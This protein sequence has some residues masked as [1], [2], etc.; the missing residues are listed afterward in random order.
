MGWMMI[1]LFFS[2]VNARNQAEGVSTSLSPL[3]VMQE[4]TTT[5]VHFL[6]LT[7]LI[8]NPISYKSPTHATYAIASSPLL[9]ILHVAGSL[10]FPL[11]HFSPLPLH[12]FLCMPSLCCVNILSVIL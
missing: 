8:L 11:N 1:R 5:L 4:S 9:S 6:E 2:L 10:F 3:P 7:F 12:S